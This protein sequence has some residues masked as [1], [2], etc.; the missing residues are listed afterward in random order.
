[1]TLDWNAFTPWT[2][3][4]GG[5]LIGL[6]ATM[7]VLLN[8]RIAGISGVLGGLL[9][10]ARGDTAWRVVFLLG[11]FAAPWLWRAVTAWPPVTIDAGTSATVAAGLLVGFG[12]RLGSGCTSG[13]GVCG[14]SRLSPRSLVATLAFMAAGFVAVWVIRH[15]FAG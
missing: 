9:P 1:M 2:A 12:T 7:F 15:L 13:H 5:A 10:P 8:G 14:L 6:A 11:L 3:L 4:A